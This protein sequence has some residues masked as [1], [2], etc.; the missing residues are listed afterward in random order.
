[1][2]Y[3]ASPSR[4][5]LAAAQAERAERQNKLESGELAP[6]GE[7][8]AQWA[9]IIISIRTRLLAIPARLSARHPG[10]QKLVAD[11][12]RELESALNVIADDEL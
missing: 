6:I 7:I 5:R 2:A 12:E 9:D 11:L 8:Q 4:E 1:M 3:K 10:S